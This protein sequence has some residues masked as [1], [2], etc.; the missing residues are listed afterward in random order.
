M[1]KQLALILTLVLLC[2]ITMTG[3]AEETVYKLPDYEITGDTVTLLT[4]GGTTKTLCETEGAEYYDIDQLLQKY[5][6]CKLKIIRTTYEELPIKAASLVLAGE[7]PD[8]IKYKDQDNPSFVQQNLVA[9]VS[10]YVDWND[11]LW[12]GVKETAEMWKYGDKY[13]MLPYTEFEN[14]SYIY[15]WTDMFEEAGLE[16]PYE[17]YLNGECT[18]CRGRQGL[19]R[20]KR[21]RYFYRVAEEMSARLSET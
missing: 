3:T 21:G 18:I 15:Y 8:L 11:P 19:E 13:Y 20:R 7:A 2:G 17:L 16:T 6:G 9:E 1:R 4:W 12:A 5:Y 14:N 10:P